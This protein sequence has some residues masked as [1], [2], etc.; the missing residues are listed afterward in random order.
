M[1]TAM[2]P[3]FTSLTFA[4]FLAVAICLPAQAKPHQTADWIGANY[5]PAYACNQVQFWHDFRP[6]VVEAE[7][8]AARKHFGIT[9]LRVYLHS[10][11]F[12]ED[13]E[14]FFKNLETFLEIC[15]RHEIRPGFCFF[16]DC[17]RHKDIF[18]DRPTEPIKSYHNGRW[19]ACPQDRDRDPKKLERFKPYIQ[20][21]I[22]AHLRDPRVR[23]WE[24]F[25]E[26]N[27]SAYSQALR[28]ASYG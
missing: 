13:R 25:N 17:H 23:F 16:D 20:E 21:I 3:L 22:R 12:E 10:I 8:T 27:G 26:P 7:L 18:L 4:F 2:K 11:N 24:V 9:S 6:A 15:D 28:R 5:T 1:D 14:T 19:A